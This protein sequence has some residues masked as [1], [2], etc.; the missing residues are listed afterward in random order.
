[1]PMAGEAGFEG[2]TGGTPAADPSAGTPNTGAEGQPDVQ[3]QV[4]TV[5]YA[6][7][8]QVNG[9]FRQT[10]GQLRQ[11]QQQ[12]TALT[13][14]LSA[15]EKKANSG[16]G[17]ST[18][19]RIEMENA[20]DALQRVMEAHPRLGKLLGIADKADELLKGYESVG[21][22]REGTQQQLV[23]GS[24]A[25]MREIVS[26]EG[27]RLDDKGWSRVETMIAAEIAQM[28]DGQARFQRGDREVIAEAFNEIKPF[29]NGFKREANASLN[30]AKNRLNRLPPAPRG[31][32][33]G[34]PAPPKFDASK[35]NAERDFWAQTDKAARQ[36]M[37]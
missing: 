24:R 33:A 12:V 26:K 6:R 25:Q 1:M 28:P 16:P 29:L 9:Q 3:P 15:L 30:D 23:V 4:Q 17:L 32:V 20:A 10:E 7:F 19:Q 27:Y 37:S 14:R 36:L 18:E 8:Q 5:P 13:E 22:L 31:G 21:S 11:A 35:P 2:D 34:Q